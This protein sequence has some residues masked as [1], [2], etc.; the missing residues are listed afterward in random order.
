[1]ITAPLRVYYMPSIIQALYVYSVFL[2][3]TTLWMSLYKSDDGEVIQHIHFPRSHSY[4]VAEPLVPESGERKELGRLQSDSW[5]AHLFLSLKSLQCSVSRGGLSYNNGSAM[6]NP[7][8]LQP[9]STPLPYGLPQM[10][11]AVNEGL[12]SGRPFKPIQAQVGNLSPREAADLPRAHKS[13]MNWRIP[14]Q[15][16]SICSPTNQK[17]FPRHLLPTGAR[18]MQGILLHLQWAYHLFSLIFTDPFH[19]LHR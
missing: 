7:Q 4:E 16:H 19:S 1:M 13:V 9:S 3:P 14:F 18:V 5:Q 10:I 2:I 15:H 6:C 11:P 17:A 12:P 8:S